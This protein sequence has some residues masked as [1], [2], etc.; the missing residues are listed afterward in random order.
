M[1]GEKGVGRLNWERC[2]GGSSKRAE[3]DAVVMTLTS[4]LGETGGMG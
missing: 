3:L 1:V 2:V 4:A